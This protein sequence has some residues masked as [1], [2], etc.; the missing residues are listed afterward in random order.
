MSILKQAREFVLPILKKENI[1]NETVDFEFKNNILYTS[2]LRGKSE[3]LCYIGGDSTYRVADLM[4]SYLDNNLERSLFVGFLNAFVNFYYKDNTT[5]YCSDYIFCFNQIGLRLLKRYGLGLNLCFIDND[6]NKY[7]VLKKNNSKV[8]FLNFLDNDFE[9]KLFNFVSNSFL[10]LCNGYC[11][12][13]QAADNILEISMMDNKNRLVIF[14]GPQSAFVN[15]I[16]NLK[17]LCFK[18]V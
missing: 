4:D 11:L 13:M 16:L 18:E 6:I 5:T 12:T 7:Y 15:S 8:E 1:L 9:N 3:G 2:F 10:V 14:F 17:K